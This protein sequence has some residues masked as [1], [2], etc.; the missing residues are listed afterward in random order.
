V[1]PVARELV[2]SC[3]LGWGLLMFP[4]PLIFAA[5]VGSLPIAVFLLSFAS[6]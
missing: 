1:K 4:A 6:S 2:A 3:L 5:F